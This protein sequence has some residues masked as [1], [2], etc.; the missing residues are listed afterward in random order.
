MRNLV[1]ATTAIITL[2][3]PCAAQSTISRSLGG[4]WDISTPGEST[5][6]IERNLSGQG[7]TVDRPGYSSGSIERNLG[8]DW[9]VKQP[10]CLSHIGCD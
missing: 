3:G 6:H 2:A 1:L 10:E 4:G 8:G 7:Y 9:V 5:T